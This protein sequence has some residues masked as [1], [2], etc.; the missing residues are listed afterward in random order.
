[1][2]ILK[3]ISERYAGLNTDIETR[4]HLIGH[5]D[6]CICRN[7]NDIL[8]LHCFLYINTYLDISERHLSQIQHLM[9]YIPIRL[10]RNDKK[11]K[12]HVGH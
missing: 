5:H 6:N 9:M 3:F 2:S 4:L 12:L 7:N 1:M 8:G 11:R 10:N